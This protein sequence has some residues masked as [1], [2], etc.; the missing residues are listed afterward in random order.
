MK[1]TKL[2]G[3]SFP[4]PETIDNGSVT[5][6]QL[7]VLLQ[8]AAECLLDDAQVLDSNGNNL[9][10]NSSFEIG[11]GGWTAEGNRIHLQPGNYRRL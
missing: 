4:I 9:I 10:T 11:S 8:G 3:P 7:Q 5:A 1:P 2:P 6:D